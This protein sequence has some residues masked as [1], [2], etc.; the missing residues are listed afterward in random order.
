MFCVFF[1]QQPLKLKY[2]TIQSEIYIDNIKH[3]KKIFP[4]KN[5][6]KITECPKNSWYFVLPASGKVCPPRGGNLLLPTGLFWHDP[7]REL[8]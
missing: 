8:K 2:Q 5:K 7:P 4:L 1:Y 3:R 6:Y